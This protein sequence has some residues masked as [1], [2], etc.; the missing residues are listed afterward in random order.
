VL[1]ATPSCRRSKTT[2][3]LVSDDKRT[4]TGNRFGGVDS[5]NLVALGNQN[6]PVGA[7]IEKAYSRYSRNRSGISGIF[8]MRAWYR[9]DGAGIT[10]QMTSR[11]LRLEA[12]R[13]LR[14]RRR[15][16]TPLLSLRWLALILFDYAGHLAQAARAFW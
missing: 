11:A 7:P 16:Q 6:P 13:A 9:K 12:M 2:L 4:I 5:R 3:C 15:P 1:N 10:S 8:R 14:S